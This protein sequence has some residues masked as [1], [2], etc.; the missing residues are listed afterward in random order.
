M[1]LFEGFFFFFNSRQPLISLRI[2]H[3]FL[4]NFPKVLRELL[5]F[6]IISLVFVTLMCDSG[7]IL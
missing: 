4:Y 7:G 5:K 1:V 6:E 3:T 2:L